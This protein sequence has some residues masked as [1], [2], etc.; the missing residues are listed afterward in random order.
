MSIS[1]SENSVLNPT[2]AIT[3][4]VGDSSGLE[5]KPSNTG[6]IVIHQQTDGK[7]LTITNEDVEEVLERYDSEGRLFLQVNFINGKKILL[8]EKL[9]GFKPIA[10]KGLD[11]KKLPKVVTTP[12]LVSVVEAIEESLNAK[13]PRFE[14][15]EVLRRVFDSVLMGAQEV[16]FDL[17]AERAWLS[18]IASLRGKATA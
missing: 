14:E 8:T 11:L 7:L 17:E 4:F 6:S 2:Q 12:D 3:D 9:V 1:D 16:G 18:C 5:V 13:N 15:V 10:T